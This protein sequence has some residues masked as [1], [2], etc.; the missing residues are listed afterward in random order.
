MKVELTTKIFSDKRFYKRLLTLMLPIMLQ[1]L[2]L[3]AV[4]AGDAVMLGRVD[5]NSMSAVSLATQIQFIQNMIL[6]AV[7]G[8]ISILGAQYWGK[9]DLKTIN[10]L[11]CMGLKLAGI[12]SLL[13]FVACI[14]LPKYLMMIFTNEPELIRIGIDYLRIAG[15][16]YLLT[17]ISQ[18]YLTVMKI[19]GHASRGAIISSGAV[20]LNIVLNA[21]FIFGF[22]CVPAMGAKGAAIATLIARV[23]ELVWAVAS[24]LQKGFLRPQLSG[25]I[26]KNKNLMIQFGKCALPL[27][28]G[29]LFWGV[30]FTSYTAIIGH[31]GADAAA[32]NS[33]SAVVRDL[34]CC[35]CNGLASAG[36]ILVGYEL[37]AGKLE[38]G[39]VYGIRLAKISFICGIGST[40]IVLALTPFVT[41]FMILTDEARSLLTGMMVIMAFYMI[42]RCV[43]TIIING[44]F[45]A[46][47]DTLFDVYS[48]AVT[49][50]GI[51]IPLALA[52]AFLWNWPVLLVFACTCI[53]EVG[54][55]PWVLYHFRKYR[56]V[57]DLTVVEE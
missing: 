30:G 46:G 28:G 51:A 35:V 29:G 38:L 22:F 41:R 53:D 31:M 20:I 26:H 44:V 13:F 57:K 23:I 55:I 12:A 6:A 34:M 21:I 10:D 5:Q 16:S 42:G 4:A 15:W 37:G 11:F 36:G 47:G 18:C 45:A 32:A 24:S 54:K 1:S 43:N 14:F 27:L 50:W 3:A 52:G 25:F 40:I 39:K 7:T 33:V 17:G 48:L 56:W 2:M 49:M 9:Q 8:G 19:S